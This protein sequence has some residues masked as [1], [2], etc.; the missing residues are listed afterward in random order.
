VVFAFL[1]IF[2]ALPILFHRYKDAIA[3]NLGIIAA[4]LLFFNQTYYLA[5]P[6]IATS[7]VFFKKKAVITAL[8]YGLISVPLMMMQ[9]LEYI[10]LIPREDWWVEGRLK[11]ANLRFSNRGLQRSCGVNDPVQV[12]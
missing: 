7:A 2:T 4:V 1:F 3:I 6:L 8:L 10:T 9:Y 11:S 5:A 12:I